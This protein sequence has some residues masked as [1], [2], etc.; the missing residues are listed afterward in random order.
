M[1]ESEPKLH[2][3]KGD[4][5]ASASTTSERMPRRLIR[6]TIIVEGIAVLIGCM[7]LVSWFLGAVR[8]ERTLFRIVPI[9]VWAV[10]VSRAHTCRILEPQSDFYKYGF[11]VAA[12]LLALIAVIMIGVLLFA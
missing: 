3:A 8:V 12:A 11:Y 5:A 4:S 10:I 6:K 1:L 2:D 7:W 9:V